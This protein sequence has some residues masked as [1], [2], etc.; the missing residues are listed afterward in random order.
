[1]SE[2]PDMT[3]RTEAYNITTIQNLVTQETHQRLSLTFNVVKSIRQKRPQFSSVVQ[4]PIVQITSLRHRYHSI[5]HQVHISPH[6]KVLFFP[7]HK[8]LFSFMAHSINSTK[9][10]NGFSDGFNTEPLSFN[11][12]PQIAPLREQLIL[13]F[14]HR[15]LLNGASINGCPQVAP[16]RSRF[17]YGQHL[18]LTV[19][20]AYFRGEIVQHQEIRM[21]LGSFVLH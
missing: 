21:K 3:H 6:Q 4:F 16:T 11:L 2:I 14:H 19:E 20:H 10:F 5:R 12:S 9:S 17:N 13:T 18:K 15:W 1:M 7:N 8:T